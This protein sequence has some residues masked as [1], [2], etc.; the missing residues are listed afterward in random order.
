MNAVN[1]FV[2]HN[3][4]VVR[5]DQDLTQAN[6]TVANNNINETVR[7]CA[8]YHSVARLELFVFHEKF[9][10]ISSTCSCINF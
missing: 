8:A 5:C 10:G 7:W 4:Y 3:V 6:V 9:S 1:G 2:V